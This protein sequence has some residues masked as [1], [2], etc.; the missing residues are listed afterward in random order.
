M[1]HTERVRLIVGG[2]AIF[3]CRRAGKVKQHAHR[4]S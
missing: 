3:L 2:E 1:M 4:Q